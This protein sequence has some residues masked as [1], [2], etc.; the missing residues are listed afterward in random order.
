MKYK[1]V[2]L[3]TLS[4]NKASIYSVIQ[5]D[6]TETFLDK[7][8]K[9]NK[10]SSLS[11][12]KNILM[13]LK[14][15]GHKTGARE[16]FFKT[17]EGYPGDGV[18][19]LY[20]EPKSKLRLYCIRFGTQ[21][22]VVGNGGPKAKTIRAFQANDKLKEENYFLRW[23]S[24]EITSRIKDKEIIYINDPLDFSGNLEF[25]DHERS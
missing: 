1:L 11:E 18:C 16:N 10:N 24:V 20:D 3:S 14:S 5:D 22:V 7:F 9:E 19:A 15:I 6:E 2:K 8:V 17:F 12:I 25:Q 4:G 21:L 23:L 13:R